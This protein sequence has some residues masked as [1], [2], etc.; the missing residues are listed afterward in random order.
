MNKTQKPILIGTSLTDDSD[1]IVR[2]G[3]AFAR[4][5]GAPAWLLHAY[6]PYFPI[7]SPSG[8]VMDPVWAAEQEKALRNLI[9]EQARR[10]GLSALPGFSADRVRLVAGAPHQEIAALAGEIGAGYIVVGASETEGLLGST[11]DRVI[12]KAACP[13]LAIRS[14]TTFP[15]RRVE[16]AVDFSEISANALRQGLRLLERLGAPVTETEALMVLAPYETAGS[17][18]FTRDQV[19]R[20]AVEEL[21][22]FLASNASPAMRPKLARV[23][24]GSP[25]ETIL[26]TLQDRQA[27]LVVL[28]THGRSGFERLMLGSVAA[29]VLHSATCNLLIVP[30]A[31]ADDS[32]EERTDADWTYVSDEDSVVVSRS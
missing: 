4:K 29:G 7:S 25:R 23:L 16:I 30:P 21:S 27:D 9:D 15:P 8:I 13:V 22:R 32:E 12:R 2:T 3:V 10:T 18:H 11:A 6:T 19:Q 14:E 20:F 26:A 5:T 31:A 28:G 1:A 17:L 24:T